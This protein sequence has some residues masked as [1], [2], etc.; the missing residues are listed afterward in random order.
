[1][2]RVVVDCLE[3]PEANVFAW[4]NIGPAWSSYF[5]IW[6]KPSFLLGLRPQSC[7]TPELAPLSKPK[8]GQARWNVCWKNATLV[9]NTT[10]VWLVVS[11]PLKKNSQLG[12]LF[13]IYIYIYYMEKQNMF[14]TTNQ[15]YTSI[16]PIP[17]SQSIQVVDQRW[18]KFKAFN[19]PIVVLSHQRCAGIIWTY[20]L[21]P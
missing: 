16:A 2:N 3:P 9:S 19:M 12:L 8:A 11:T 4:F 6:C 18:S 1:M 10:L 5:Y 7:L 13:T 14:Q 15:L 20:R 21:W 17:W